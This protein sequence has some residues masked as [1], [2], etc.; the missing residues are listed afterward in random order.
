MYLSIRGLTCATVLS[1]ALGASLAWGAEKTPSDAPPSKIS[2]V[3]EPTESPRFLHD[4]QQLT[5]GSV[6]VAG[7]AIAYQAEA[8][9]LVV[10]VKDPLDEDPPLPK[11]DRN[12]PPPPQPPEVAMS[13]VAYFRGDK[14]DGH[15]PITFIYNGGPGSPTSSLP[16]SPFSPKPLP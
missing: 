11:E 1:I 16:I 5:S 15:R 7:R 4:E 8:G 3:P 13:Y 2:L 14:E 10:H 6:T 9:L 12:G